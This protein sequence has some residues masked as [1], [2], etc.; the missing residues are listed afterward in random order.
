MDLLVGC[1]DRLLQMGEKRN[2]ERKTV[3]HQN[4]ETN[5]CLWYLVIT[6]K[7]ENSD[8]LNRKRILIET[9]GA[10]YYLRYKAQESSGFGS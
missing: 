4:S 7:V 1:S 9:N 6:T 2:K 8:L 10:Y 3:F 5:H